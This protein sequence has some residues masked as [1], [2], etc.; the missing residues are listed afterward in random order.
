MENK[1]ALEPLKPLK[2]L[3]MDVSIQRNKDEIHSKAETIMRKQDYC[4]NFYKYNKVGNHPKAYKI[5]FNHDNVSNENILN[6]GKCILLDSLKN[7]MKF[8]EYMRIENVI[9]HQIDAIKVIDNIK[10][11]LIKEFKGIIKYRKDRALTQDQMR[12]FAI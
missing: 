2:P 12:C 5:E 4:N 7:P 11:N 6:L 3:K 1:I 8:S 9:N 10:D